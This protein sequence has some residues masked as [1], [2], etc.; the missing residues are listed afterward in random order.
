MNVRLNV[1]LS[2]D[3]RIKLLWP[4]TDPAYG[5]LRPVLE[6]WLGDRLALT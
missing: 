4:R 5:V 3:T 6:K 2:D 1:W